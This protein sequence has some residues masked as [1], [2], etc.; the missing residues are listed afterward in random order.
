MA[1][2]LPFDQIAAGFPKDM[3]AEQYDAVRRKYFDEVVA[4][5]LDRGSSPLAAWNQFKT[6]TERKSTLDA[7]GKVV[8]P[9]AQFASGLT[10]SLT[11][12]LASVTKSKGLKQVSDLSEQAEKSLGRTAA[13]EGR[14]QLPT[15]AG[16]MVGS[17][18]PIALAAET[19]G[20][21]LE[22]AG[23]DSAT[24]AYKLLRGGIA[25]G[26]FEAAYADEG[27]RLTAGVKGFGVGLAFE[28]AL[29]MG[30]K[31]LKRGVPQKEIDSIVTK[32]L[33]G[34][35]DTTPEIAQDITKSVKNDAVV[36]KQEGRPQFVR[37]DPSTKG[38]SVLLHNGE[39]KAVTLKVRSGNEHAIVKQVMD[40][41]NAGGV[42]DGIIHHPNDIALANRFMRASADSGAQKYEGAKVIRTE[43]GKAPQIAL[44]D[45]LDGKATVAVEGDKV[46]TQS[47]QRS[48]PGGPEI[49]A[50]VKQLRD[51]DGYELSRGAQGSIA[52][53]V[54]RLWRN[55]VPDANKR[56]AAD[57]LK[58]WELGDLIPEQWRVEK[59]LPD[60]IEKEV[61]GEDIIARAKELGVSEVEL[62]RLQEV[63]AR[64]PVRVGGER[65][66][67]IGKTPLQGFAKPSNK[68]VIMYHGTNI[69]S[70]V[71]EK[72]GLKVNAS[73]KDWR[74]GRL[75]LGRTPEI[76]GW[77]PE[78]GK[79]RGYGSQIFEVEVPHNTLHID[80]ET[81]IG[82]GEFYIEEDIPPDRIRRFNLEPQAVHNILIPE[83]EEHY[84]GYGEGGPVKVPYV[85]GANV[86][87]TPR[88]F[89]IQTSRRAIQTALPGAAA[90][91]H[92][93][94]TLNTILN[95]LGIFSQEA[96][97]RSVL[98]GIAYEGTPT[99][100][101]AYHE[102]LHVDKFHISDGEHIIQSYDI[103]ASPV[104]TTVDEI[105]NGLRKFGAYRDMDEGTMREEAYV[106]VATAI[107]TG[108]VQYLAELTKMDGSINDLF[109]MVND[110]SIQ[111]MRA[112]T[113]AVDSA[114]VRVFQRKL[115]DLI[116]RTTPNKSHELMDQLSDWMGDASYDPASRTWK[117][118]SLGQLA[119][120][121]YDS[122]KALIDE[123]DKRSSAE[124]WAPSASLFAEA[125][126]VRGPINPRGGGP[127]KDPIAMD[128]PPNV[129]W[130]GWTSISGWMRPMGPWV[131]DLH[132]RVNEALSAS[133]KRLPIYDR[134]KD[135]D[136]AFRNGDNW[137]QD[138]YDSAAKMLDGLGPK[139]NDYFNV[140]TTDPVHWP[141]MARQLNLNEGD[142]NK[143]KQIDDWL[144]KFRDDTNILV[145]NY[146]RDELPRLRN[147]DYSTEHVYGNLK[148]TPD[149]MSTFER[150]I[151]QGKLDPRAS[152]I[153]SF[154]DT[155]L[156]EGFSKKFTD[157]PLKKLE[158]LVE[159]K[160]KD[161][162]Y[163]LGNMRHPLVNYTRYMRGIPDVTGQIM[164]KTVGDFFNFVGERTT[165]MNK[166]LPSYAQLP[167]EFKYPRSY[168]NK[169]LVWSY[170]AGLGLRAAIPIRDAMQVFST[171]LPVLGP[172]KF[173][174]GLARFAKEGFTFADEQGALL[175]RRNIGELYGDI[176]NELPPGASTDRITKFANKLLAPSR[177]GHNVGRAI[178]FY[179]EYD[180]ALEGV[181]AYRAGRIN[182]DELIKDRTSLWWNDKPAIDRIMGQIQDSG[183]SNEEIARNIALETTDL[184]L[185]PY[186]RGTQPTILRTGMGRVFGQFGMWPMNYFDFLKRGASKFAEHPQN[187]MK[188][189]AMWAACNYG[190]VAALNGI[191]A[192]AGKWFW[193]SPAGID[194]SPHAKFVEDLGMMWKE[195]PDGREARR[196]VLEYP[197]NFFPSS[198][199]AQ[200]VMKVFESGE[201]PFDENG[202][203]TAA[204]LQILG[205]KPLKETP[206]RDLEEEI[207]F[208]TGFSERARH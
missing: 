154:I 171:T 202:K 135:V 179:G 185:W 126:G 141:E 145:K 25:F 82:S 147:Y 14:S 157:A 103:G 67:D 42:V 20:A 152:H 180:S 29:G 40:I 155:M 90:I 182:A 83:S 31:L 104:L 108:D 97:T 153:G 49:E 3:P 43:P 89:A 133:G 107:R 56:V 93:P 158:Q 124:T 207:K 4:P 44:E 78:T 163:V 91:T 188:T 127:V 161:G 169:L 55:D 200:S 164:N 122:Y 143:I 36:S 192:D 177:W 101:Y 95:R 151:T 114:P 70:E 111:L 57:R 17:V 53:D 73:A 84:I 191:G 52:K 105:A 115:S 137:L 198:L 189:T 12:P 11:K 123:V 1:D 106:H 170:A 181:D 34:D 65:F 2:P 27:N 76:V 85:E 144:G 22:M 64:E 8:L 37:E 81:G 16:E 162:S 102:G 150:M 203:P 125:R 165:Q 172:Q 178:G 61:T 184:T 86:G 208:E 74:K 19:G 48:T 88:R 60:D 46:V 66:E 33:S 21:S 30:G 159:L 80:K 138:N 166:H 175:K 109:N 131:N 206:D 205:F 121:T 193:V 35:G 26:A 129:R 10:H 112:T 79:V 62:N 110:R 32:V 196:R 132:L 197:L 195:S 167:T 156:R 113:E 116:L 5:R 72:E 96:E 47:T 7:T 50:G 168:I 174:R 204:L 51:E 176:F 130:G 68:T 117:L 71:I 136:E 54:K 18:A 69:S 186:R 149:Q 75:Y 140:L 128:T 28:G 173:A 183:F 94:A 199:E 190:A 87:M 13:R 99:K 160:A 23:L 118:K 59:P 6:N 134:W 45:N 142:L 146:L 58:S 98:P 38:V 9:I 120:E 15:V 41:T 92:P 63:H 187:A 139:Q 100:A 201:E 24:T 148:K 119:E 39:G 77:E 194:M